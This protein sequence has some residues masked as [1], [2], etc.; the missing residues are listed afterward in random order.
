M[1]LFALNRQFNWACRHLNTNLSP[2]ERHR[3]RALLL[4]QHTKDVKLTRRTF[5]LSRPTLYRWLHRFDPNNLG[6]LR[7]RSRK[8]HR[9]TRPQWP[10]ALKQAI[11][12]LTEQYP[13]WGKNKLLVLLQNEGFEVSAPTVGRILNSV[14]Q[15]GQL[16][17]PKFTNISAKRRRKPRPYAIG[18]PK[19]YQPLYPGDL[20]QIDTL[21]IGPVPGVIL[22]QFTARDV[23][24]RWDVLEVHRQA[25]AS[26]AASFIHTI[27]ARMPLGIR[28]LQVHGGSELFCDFETRCQ[29][30]GIR[31][32]VVAPKSPKLNG[33]VQ[34][35]NRTHTEEFYEVQQCA[36]TVEALNQQLLEWERTYN[37]V[38]PH[39][40]LNDL[41]PLQYLQD[42]GIVARYIRLTLQACRNK[43]TAKPRIS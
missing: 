2:N 10:L 26:L 12:R 35:A 39:Q 25:S 27:K 33:A 24:S 6:P 8:P 36:W 19:D 38:R 13:R 21:D 29:Q 18:K 42:R 43:L 3:L 14:R 9:F 17:E 11:L 41:T 1:T 20:V 40:A 4:C 5:D 16:L 22:K 28:A 37:T 7:E 30:H 23:V 34:R 31:L 32:F 15:R